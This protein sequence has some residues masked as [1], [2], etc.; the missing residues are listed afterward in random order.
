MDPNATIIHW[1]GPK[2]EKCLPCYLDHLELPP[3]QQAAVCKQCN[4]TSVRAMFEAVP[5][6]GELF[7]LGTELHWKY[8]NQSL[9]V[10]G[11]LRLRRPRRQRAIARGAPRVVVAL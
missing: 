10:M 3:R 2:P 4:N 9:A 11:A 7:A 6:G 5:D 1:Q 8:V